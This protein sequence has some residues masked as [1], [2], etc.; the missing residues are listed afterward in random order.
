MPSNIPEAMRVPKALL[1]IF[2]QYSIHILRPSSLRVYHFEIKNK[3]PGKKAAST[4]PRKNR[5]RRAPINLIDIQTIFS[6]PDN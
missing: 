5:V 4:K 1:M 3:A 6:N 2:P